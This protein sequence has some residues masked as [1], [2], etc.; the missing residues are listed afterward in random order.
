M[1]EITIDR[2]AYDVLCDKVRSLSTLAKQFDLS[3]TRK[4]NV[5]AD[6]MKQC[7]DDR[8]KIVDRLENLEDLLKNLKVD[9]NDITNRKRNT[10][11][12]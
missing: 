9:C 2:L 11:E 4:L 12:G 5:V 8:V 6:L 10:R 7:R 3:T 1:S